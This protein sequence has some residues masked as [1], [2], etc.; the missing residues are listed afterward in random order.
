MRSATII[1]FLLV[2][3]RAIGDQDIDKKCGI[4][5]TIIG[6]EGTDYVVEDSYNDTSIF[7]LPTVYLKSGT[8]I[9]MAHNANNIA[10]TGSGRLRTVVGTGANKGDIRFTFNREWSRLGWSSYGTASQYPLYT[11]SFSMT[12]LNTDYYGSGQDLIG[13]VGGNG[14]TQTNKAT[15]FY[16]A[17]LDSVGDEWH[18]LRYADDDFVDYPSAEPDATSSDGKW[19]NI[20]RDPV[21]PAFKTSASD[22]SGKFY[23]TPPKVYFM[24]V[25]HPE[26]I[27]FQ[28]NC[29][30]AITNIFGG[31]ISYDIN[32]GATVNVG[33]ATVTLNQANFSSGSNTLRYWYT[34]TPSVK[35]TRTLVK[36]PTSPSAGE[37]HGNLLW[38]DAA[39]LT[40]V[41][42]RIV[43]AP[44]AFKYARFKGRNNYECGQDE[45]DDNGGHGYRL[46]GR[47]AAWAMAPARNNAFVALVEGNSYVVPGSVK[48]AAIY[49]KEMMIESGLCTPVL[50]SELQM[51]SIPQASS[52]TNYRG[53]EDV[54]AVYH[55]AMAYDWAAANFRSDQVSGGMTPI[56]EYFVRDM[57]AS[58]VHFCGLWQGGFQDQGEPGLW[59]TARNTGA[60]VAAMALP[61]YSTPY[62]GTSGVDG[63]TTTYTWAPFQTTNYTWKNL[64]IT[65]NYSLGSYPNAPIYSFGWENENDA[66]GLCNPDG[67]WT[68]RISYATDGQMGYNLAVY[69]NLQKMYFPAV[70]HTYMDA[71]LV[72][73]TAGT[74]M[75]LKEEPGD[76]PPPPYGPS[77]I[78]NLGVVN[79]NFPVFAANAQAYA[80]GLPNDDTNSVFSAIDVMGLFSFTWYDDTYYG[81]SGAALTV[82][83]ANITTLNVSP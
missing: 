16:R 73:A 57:I 74:V 79:E 21:T 7:D 43:R 77:R 35:R 42:G 13:S 12:S 41:E 8:S 30:F 51:S 62:Y 18:V 1:L 61:S 64:F 80:Q 40:V 71:Y 75:Y 49:A 68:D 53:Y 23:K 65:G 3:A 60:M 22:S 27:Y 17:I 29:S 54:E 45:W 33:A 76:T 11:G 52:E 67:E 48:T 72:N 25:I 69:R 24:P 4:T 37:D 36:S 47:T 15:F 20:V 38:G 19:F 46:G 10:V 28:G 32:G 56:E 81:E 70:D 44:Y 2:L 78:T 82:S 5:V 31:N 26:T 59:G 83:T 9:S 6:T 14:Q 39:G 50:G 66:L 34:A 58:W 63:N 55:V